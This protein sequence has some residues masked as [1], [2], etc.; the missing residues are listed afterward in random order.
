MHM[1]ALARMGTPR[2]YKDEYIR[3][4]H[5]LICTQARWRIRAHMYG[6][7]GH[8]WMHHMHATDTARIRFAANSA[9]WKRSLHDTGGKAQEMALVAVNAAEFVFTAVT[10]AS[11]ATKAAQHSLISVQHAEKQ[12]LDF[13]RASGALVTQRRTLLGRRAL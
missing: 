8:L 12:A 6:M 7:H 13:A 5:R 2:H 10:A 1:Y 9:I 3:H 4:A 11:V